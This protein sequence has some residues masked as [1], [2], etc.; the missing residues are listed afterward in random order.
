VPGR[1]DEVISR[2]QDTRSDSPRERITSMP[3]APRSAAIRAFSAFMWA[4][5]SLGVPSGVPFRTTTIFPATS[6]PA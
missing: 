1:L 5:T 3:T 2:F 4:L 6:S